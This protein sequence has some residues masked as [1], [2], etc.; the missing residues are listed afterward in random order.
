MQTARRLLVVMVLAFTLLPTAVVGKPSSDGD[1][2]FR[3]N[4]QRTGEQPGPGPLSDPV[5]QWSFMA[6]GPIVVGAVAVDGI[7]YLGSWDHYLYA[8]DQATG[9]VR[10]RF[11]A[12]AGF[13][14]SPAYHAGVLYAGGNDGVLYAVDAATGRE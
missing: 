1:L 4:L 2:F 5:L 14:S 9:R 7:V 6:A 8:L 13:F 11:E 3:G 12:G 10:W